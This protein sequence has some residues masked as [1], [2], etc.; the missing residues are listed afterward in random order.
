[1]NYDNKFSDFK[2]IEINYTD[3]AVLKREIIYLITTTGMRSLSLS[4][5]RFMCR[6][7]L[8]LVLLSHIICLFVAKVCF[9]WRQKKVKCIKDSV[10]QPE[11]PL[12]FIP[13]LPSRLEEEIK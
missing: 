1:M 3:T 6:I 9:V 8:C 7:T 12:S 13:D 2:M 11:Q 10:S 5:S 4:L